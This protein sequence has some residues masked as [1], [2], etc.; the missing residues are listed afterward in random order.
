MDPTAPL[1]SASSLSLR[2]LVEA[3]E[4]AGAASE[5]LLGP[6]G[7]A[8]SRLQQVEERFE[9]FDFAGLQERAARLAGNPAL[10]LQMGQ[11]TSESALDSLAYLAGHAPTL[12]EAVEVI[13]RF[14]PLALDGLHLRMVSNGDLVEIHTGFPHTTPMAD[15]MLA[16]FLMSGMLRLVRHLTGSSAHPRLVSFEHERPDYAEA[17]ARMFEGAERFGRRATYIAFDRGLAEVRQLH[18]SPELFNVVR[19][20]SERKLRRLSGALGAIERLRRYLL[21]HDVAELPDMATAARDLAMSE[22]SLR[23][24]LAAQG[25]SYREVVRATRHASASRMLRDPSRTIQETAAAVGY[26]DARTFHRAFKAW[27]GMTPAQY[28]RSHGVG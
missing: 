14:A 2:V 28:R 26:V 12:R 17:Y 25:S 16:E 10:G 24:H 22:R 4:R 27:T 3:V 21:T 13:A 6:S 7:I 9:L 8:R 20:E 5:A 11:R 18:L 15:R 23:R 19:A 1:P